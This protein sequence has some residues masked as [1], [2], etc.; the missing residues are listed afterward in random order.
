MRGRC[1][2]RAPSHAERT[3]HAPLEE[4][5]KSTTGGDGRSRRCHL[6]ERRLTIR[7]KIQG[8]ERPRGIQRRAPDKLLGGPSELFEEGEP[9][10]AIESGNVE[11][12]PRGSDVSRHDMPDMRTLDEVSSAPEEPLPPSWLSDGAAMAQEEPSATSPPLDLSGAASAWWCATV[13][14]FELELHHVRSSRKRPSRGIGVSN[15]GRWSI[16]RGS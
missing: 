6:Q 4:Q 8:I 2:R 5:H 7:D 15:R 14:E 9:G 11:K 12:A 10:A 3:S 1:V 16:N 13:K